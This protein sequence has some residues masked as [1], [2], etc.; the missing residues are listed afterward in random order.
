MNY[1]SFIKD[2]ERWV[3]RKAL[4]YLA[5]GVIVGTA[6][7]GGYAL[8]NGHHKP[9]VRTKTE[10][11]QSV[12]NVG[13]IAFVY[14]KDGPFEYDKHGFTGDKYEKEIYLFDSNGRKLRQLTKNSGCVEDSEPVWSPDGRWI[15][16]VSD[17]DDNEEIYALDPSSKTLINL[18][19]NPA[20]DYDPAWSPDGNKLAFISTRDGNPEVYS[21]N[22]DGTNQK[23][24]TINPLSDAHPRWLADEKR[25]I[26]VSFGKNPSDGT[27]PET[28]YSEINVMN[29]DGSDQKELIYD[30][31]GA[32]NEVLPSPSA[33]IAA[34]IEANGNLSIVDINT[35]KVKTIIDEHTKLP[36]SIGYTQLGPKVHITE[37]RFSP[38]GKKL[39]AVVSEEGGEPDMLYLMN[40]DSTINEKIINYA[41]GSISWS[42]DGKYIA[43]SGYHEISN[44]DVIHGRKK[45]LIESRYQYYYPEWQPI[46][47]GG[48]E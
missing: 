45:T 14:D 9:G 1:K 42:P 33:S 44:V 22:A 30:D 35:G 38:D 39:A 13:K 23:K 28:T 19:K 11:S 41:I 43:F 27:H 4:P 3:V 31:Y 15:A 12:K 8:A 34:F 48:R 32:V 37:V 21:M 17:R 25:I 47:K 10:A 16:F 40:I 29:Q 36:T 7:F 26:F 46:P 20:E 2:V 5:A 24:L 6:L 18:T